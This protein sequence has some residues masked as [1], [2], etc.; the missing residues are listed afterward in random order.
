MHVHYSH[1]ELGTSEGSSDDQKSE[2][3][4]DVLTSTASSFKTMIIENAETQTCQ[5]GSRSKADCFQSSMFPFLRHTKRRLSWPTH[6]PT[7]RLSLYACSVQ[8]CNRVD[9][10][11]DYILVRA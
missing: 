1:T 10:Y 3:D 2:C 9:N 4:P 7:L 6:D 11:N 8:L 5:E